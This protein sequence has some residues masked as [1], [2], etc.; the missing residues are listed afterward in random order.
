MAI[1]SMVTCD[2]DG[3]TATHPAATCTGWEHNE[4][5]DYCPA[6]KRKLIMIRLARGVD[7]EDFYYQ[8]LKALEDDGVL[9]IV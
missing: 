8:H 6:H 9:E 4:H 5:G 3:C 7:D 2:G 1:I